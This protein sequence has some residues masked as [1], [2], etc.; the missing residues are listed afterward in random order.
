MEAVKPKRKHKKKEKEEVSRTTERGEAA[1][2]VKGDTDNAALTGQEATNAGESSENPCSSEIKEDDATK[3][4]LPP[5]SSAELSEN[6]VS[7]SS[8]STSSEVVGERTAGSISLN[9]E[10]QILEPKELP[11]DENQ[12]F[13][14]SRNDQT[15]N[16]NGAESATVV[17]KNSAAQDKTTR[18][19]EVKG[20]SRHSEDSSMIEN[21]NKAID[22][23]KKLTQLDVS[24]TDKTKD[25]ETAAVNQNTEESHRV[26]EGE[27]ALNETKGAKATTQQV[28]DKAV[29]ASEMYPK[30]NSVASEAVSSISQYRT[31]LEAFSEDHLKTLYFNPLLE[32]MEGFVDHFLRISK[33]DDHEF[34]ELVNA[35]FRGRNTLAMAVEEYKIVLA[36]CERKKDQLWITKDFTVTAQG[37]CLDQVNVSHNHAYQQVELNQVVPKEIE[38]LLEKLQKALHETLALQKYTCQLARLHVDT[39]IYDMLR[40]SPTLA[41]VSTDTLVTELCPGEM[42]QELQEE[43][44]KL[45]DCI[46]VLFMFVRQ[47]IKDEEFVTILNG[48]MEQLVAVLLRVASL[49][50]LVFLLNHMLRC[51]PGFASQI[52]HFIQFPVPKFKTHGYN[53]VDEPYYWD[54]PLVHHFVAMLAGVLQPIRERE[55]FLQKLSMGKQDEAFRSISWTI[56]DEDGESLED[57]DPQTCWMLIQENDLIAIFSQ[58]PFD[59][60]FKHLLKMDPNIPND[61]LTESHYHIDHT[62]SRDI[63]RMLAFASCTVY[64]M[65]RAFRTYEKIR[66]RA[67]VKRVGRTIRQIVQYV[68]DHWSDYR[69]WRVN[70]CTDSNT[71]LSDQYSLERL[72]VEVDQFFLRAAHQIISAHRLGAWQ[73]LADMPFRSV[74][75]ETLWKLFLALHLDASKLDSVESIQRENSYKENWRDILESREGEFT[76]QLAR[77]SQSEAIFLLT[78]FANIATSREENEKELIEAITL[79]VYKVSFIASQT[80]ELCSK[81]GKHLLGTI[82]STHPFVITA[83]LDSISATIETIGKACVYLFSGLSVH[84]WYPSYKS[85]DCI[86]SWLLK[87]DLSSPEHQLARYII[88]NLNWGHVGEPGESDRLFLHQCWHRALA[89]SLVEV[90]ALRLPNMPGG[91]AHEAFKEDTGLLKQMTLVAAASYNRMMQPNYEQQLYDWLWEVMLTLRLHP[92][93]LPVPVMQFTQQAPQGEELQGGE[94]ESPGFSSLVKSLSKGTLD[95]AFEN[96]L[97][98]MTHAIKAGGQLA[99][100]AAIAMT[101]IGTSRDLFLGSGLDYLTIIVNEKA[102]GAALRI[103]ANLV[104]MYFTSPEKLTQEARFLSVIHR[105]SQL[106]SDNA[107]Y[108]EKLL[109][110]ATVG[111]YCERLVG[112][113]QSHVQKFQTSLRVVE[114]WS[115]TLCSLPNWYRDVSIQFLLDNLI[116]IAVRVEGGLSV[117]QTR[118]MDGYNVLLRETGSQGVI[119]SL[120]SWVTASSN[121]PPVLWDIKPTPDYSYYAYCV[122]CIEAQMEQNCG[123]T[124]EI[125]KKLLKKPDAT[126]DSVLKKVVKKMKLSWSPTLSNLS[127]YRWASQAM[128][129]DMDHPM[130][131]LIWQQFFSLYLQRPVTQ[132][133]LAQ[134]SGVGY[135]FFEGQSHSSTL[136][137][138]KQRLQSTSEHHRNKSLETGADHDAVTDTDIEISKQFEQTRALHEKMA[139]FYQTLVLWLDEPRLHDASLYLPSLPPPY[140]P[141][142]LETLLKSEMERW[143]DLLFTNKIDLEITESVRCWIKHSFGPQKRPVEGK[144]T[145]QWSDRSPETAASRIIRRMRT[146]PAPLP[147]PPVKRLEPILPPMTDATLMN[148]QKV[149]NI[150]YT[151]IQAIVNQARK[152]CSHVCRHVSLDME[153]IELLPK[154]YS[155]EMS[156]VVVQVACR[157]KIYKDSHTC[158]GPATLTIKFLAKRSNEVV[159]RQVADN[160]R[161]QEQVVQNFTQPCTAQL[162]EGAAYVESIITSLVNKAKAS[163]ERK[164]TEIITDIGTAL[165]YQVCGAMDENV[166]N[167]QPTVQFFTSCVEIIGK[168]FI[169]NNPSQTE[170]LLSAI[171]EHSSVSM[172]SVPFFSPNDNPDSFTAMYRRILESADGAL[173]FSLLTKFDVSTWLSSQS[174]NL[175]DRSSLTSAVFEALNIV[176][177]EPADDKRPILEVYLRHLS[178]MLEYNFPE[179]YS[180]TLRLLCE[181]SSK[182]SLCLDVWN[183]FLSCIG[184]VPATENEQQNSSKEV[185]GDEQVLETLDW[186]TRYFSSQRA[187][188]GGHV[189]GGLYTMWRPYIKQLS[190]LLGFMCQQI[191]VRKAAVVF[192]NRGQGLDAV[193]TELWTLI[194]RVFEPWI[195]AQDSPI[196]GNDPVAPW[197]ESEVTQASDMVNLFT[198]TLGCLQAHLNAPYSSSSS[199]NMFWTFFATSLAKPGVPEF[200]LRVYNSKFFS[201]PWQSFYPTLHNME[202]MLESYTVCKNSFR[203]LGLVFPLL[204]WNKIISVYCESQ[205]AEAISRLHSSLFHLLVIFSNE[206]T[207]AVQGMKV[208]LD[209][210]L[211]F[212]WHYLDGRSFEAVVSWQI[213]HGKAELV[214]QEKSSIW[215]ALRLIRAA[216]GIVVSEDGSMQPT[217]PDTAVK[218]SSYVRCI[219]SLLSE[220]SI[221]AKLKPKSFGPAILF[222]LTDIQSVA[223]SGVDPASTASEVCFMMS[224]QLNL[225]NNCSPVGDVPKV[226]SDFILQFI[227]DSSCTMLVLA[228][229]PAACRTLAS[230]QWMVA[231]VET[232]I[233]SFFAKHSAQYLTDSQA[234]ADG[235]WEVIVPSVAFPE[236]AQDEFV[237]ECVKQGALLTLYTNVLLKLASCQSPGQEM[238]ILNDI[239]NWCTR[240]KLRREFETKVTLLWHKILQLAVRQVYYGT[241]PLNDLA[242]Q[243]SFLA[244]SLHSLGEDKASSGLLGAIGLGKK[245]QLSVKFRFMCRALEAFLLA[246]MPSNSLLRLEAKAAGYVREPRKTKQS[247]PGGRV[248]SSTAEAEQALTSLETLRS[249]KHYSA[250]GEHIIQAHSFIANPLHSLMDGPQFVVT[251]VQQLFPNERALVVMATSSNSFSN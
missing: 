160:R 202:L 245:S 78:T 233:E 50:D 105:L 45:R 216:A 155:N 144:G 29:K 167:Y 132:P 4:E 187:E 251:L 173:V 213:S 193:L 16:L 72:Q 86:K 242:K 210:S 214:I 219:T 249:N 24:T 89:A 137:K 199:M 90:S 191:V 125:S 141:A 246:Q 62:S 172:L 220:C 91:I 10:E 35:Y 48:W 208:L 113:I 80:R 139:G 237:Q 23:S 79:Q 192:S 33:Q 120:L 119:A 46:S 25:S 104:P 96:A 37:K 97:T 51:P 47:P 224:E 178:K 76:D 6:Q 53:V 140:D 66:Y 177:H 148:K 3:I 223:G 197:N 133:G 212:P 165:F 101:S 240:I 124:I 162:C 100:Y 190:F 87:A 54:N 57:E 40:N 153:Y 146:Q 169:M 9:A 63:M 247:A 181:G 122:L 175:I 203:F 83:L 130:L 225:L 128:V 85:M 19:N 158:R 110:A 127:I 205:T 108:A 67:F 106:D 88:S 182:R 230:I 200:V 14:G 21:K 15:D 34:Y 56:V 13:I 73:F 248:V 156:Q 44:Q 84:L 149:M 131:P 123:L 42:T 164:T 204:D 232:G 174:S 201:L 92:G 43:I 32:Q 179:Q 20:D 136:K 18:D 171:L 138:M 194:C 243:L 71:V 209:N 59:A 111:K 55:G 180:D 226:I 2:D 65:G 22:E 112:I 152:F 74:S 142:R 189:T 17:L 41:N 227:R 116:K 170:Q 28:I 218:R 5:S 60:I 150:V 27:S 68:L 154:M 98:S 244:S 49:A 186:L 161:E 235:G 185:L 236:L 64:M 36:E 93:D 206:Q 198:D 69:R 117:I 217:R 82:S 163:S 12:D 143:C 222:V 115:L 61:C 195:C 7:S 39:Y 11:E 166:M 1:E 231:V 135:R 147:P 94:E 239:V 118:L 207:V 38:T 176:G 151:Q 121:A 31:T 81:T 52:A 168:T 129:T 58:F 103:V 107:G 134:R 75:S 77:I 188:L 241:G 229:I 99:C 184:C 95:L 234:H 159:I 215:Y 70:I 238:C 30:L 145:G 26:A 250:L 126:V 183:T 114:F 157:S 109:Q 102:Y 211:T 228:S 196:P 221:D 8:Q